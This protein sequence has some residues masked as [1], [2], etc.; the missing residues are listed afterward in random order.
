MSTQCPTPN[1]EDQ[2]VSLSVRNLTLDLSGMG[3][4]DS[5]YATAGI[6]LEI[7]GSHKPSCHDKVETPSGEAMKITSLIIASLIHAK[8]CYR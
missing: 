4:P 7:M 1:L 5:S 3:D 2:G 8:S 6:A